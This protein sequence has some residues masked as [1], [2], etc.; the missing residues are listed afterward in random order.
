MTNLAQSW[1]LVIGLAGSL[2][3]ATVARGQGCTP[4]WD[5]SLFGLGH[6]PDGDVVS[7]AVHDDGSGSALYVGGSFA[8]AG[9]LPV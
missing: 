2:L 6:G 9:S 4:Q 7:L 8:H 1:W 3:L 5:E